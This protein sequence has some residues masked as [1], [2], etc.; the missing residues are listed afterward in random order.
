MCV[1]Q[2]QNFKSGHCLLQL[3]HSHVV[4]VI[5]DGVSNA[6]FSGCILV[7]PTQMQGSALRLEIAGYGPVSLMWESISKWL[8]V[9]PS[10]PPVP[11]LQSCSMIYV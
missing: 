2:N 5:P 7:P 4:E 3:G 8:I 6:V 1:S 9:P 11:C 10:G